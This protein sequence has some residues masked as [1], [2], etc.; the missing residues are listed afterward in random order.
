M[1]A[2]VD[3]S[4]HAQATG[5]GVPDHTSDGKPCVGGR[6]G[7]E[8]FKRVTG[9]SRDAGIVENTEATSDPDVRPV[10]GIGTRAEGHEY[11]RE[12]CQHAFHS[13]GETPH[14]GLQGRFMGIDNK[15]RIRAHRFSSLL[16]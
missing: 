2:V 5:E 13:I 3:F 10:A 12:C 11:H 8:R 4:L 14:A 16:K 6:L 7:V 15:C 9:G 1:S